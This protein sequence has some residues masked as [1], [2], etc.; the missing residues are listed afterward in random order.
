MNVEYP[1]T[2]HEARAKGIKYF[3]TG[4]PCKRGHVVARYS[5]NGSCALCNSESSAKALSPRQQAQED[6]ES[7]YEGKPCRKCGN[8]TKDVSGRR[9]TKCR[10]HR[11]TPDEI[12]LLIVTQPHQHITWYASKARRKVSAIYDAF[13][14]LNIPRR[15]KPQHY[16]G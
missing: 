9:C 1:A 7:T 12:K 4:K 13:Q 16:V 10:T 6:G 11:M 15:G 2:I 14:A 3:F 8:T 5:A